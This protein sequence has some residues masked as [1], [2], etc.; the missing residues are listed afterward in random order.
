MN[1][2]KSKQRKRLN[3]DHLSD[4]MRIKIYSYLTSEKKYVD[5]VYKE[6]DSM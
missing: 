6:C 3:A 5:E 4:L 1:L 2:I